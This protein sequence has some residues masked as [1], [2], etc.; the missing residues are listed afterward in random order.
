MPYTYIVIP[1]SDHNRLVE[2]VYRKRGFLPDE[3]TDA[4]L[5]CAEA[6]RHGIRM[7]NA[8]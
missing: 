1:E 5:L 2:T 7:R 8:I 6:A 3:C 4:A